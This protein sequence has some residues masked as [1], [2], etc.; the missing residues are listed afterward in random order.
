MK[1]GSW[2]PEGEEQLEADEQ[3]NCY[4]WF[5]KACKK[6]ATTGEPIHR[7]SF[8]QLQNGIWELKHYRLRIS[9]YDTDGSGD[10]EPLIDRDSYKG[11]FA[12]RPW[13]EDF[14]EY[15]RLTTAFGKAN[16]DEHIILAQEVRE[17]DLEHDRK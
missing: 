13:P 15:L 1:S 12:S 3:I 8:N 5:V 9:F 6:I 2:A 11:T 17:E 14:E 7:Q 4:A 10:Y 16:Q